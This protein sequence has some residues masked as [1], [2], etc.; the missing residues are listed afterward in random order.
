LKAQPLYY[1]V[2]EDIKDQIERQELKP[3]DLLPTENY[4]CEKY[5]VSRVTI[6][7]SISELINEGLVERD[8]GKAARVAHKQ[9]DRS[10]NR[11]GSLFEELEQSGI[12]SF[13]YILS[14]QL[15][16]ADEKM[17][18]IMLIPQG[19]ELLY[20][21]RV[22]YANDVPIS[23]QQIYVRTQLCP[24][25]TAEDMRN[26][27]LYGIIENRYGLSI[28]YADQTISSVIATPKQ[29]AL[30]EL[31]STTGLLR[32]NR[33][34]YLTDECCVEYSKSLYVPSRYTLT[35]RLYR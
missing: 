3:G 6:R 12:R 1:R 34:T 30:L 25:L 22:R 11:L 15:I 26:Q 16:H 23:L 8:F 10:M 33:T 2:K 19:E 31:E 35:M 13:S 32:V 29:A 14:S 18:E 21:H 5:K 17:A 4:L 9:F 28:K 24:N 27:S 7:K 20:V